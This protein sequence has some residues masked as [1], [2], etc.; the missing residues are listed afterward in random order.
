MTLVTKQNKRHLFVH[1][2]MLRATYSIMQLI[3]K[4]LDSNNTALNKKILLMFFHGYR[5]DYYVKV[6]MYNYKT[7]HG[8]TRYYSKNAKKRRS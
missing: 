1:V 4:Y 5:M 7:D 6:L 2:N 3:N 8:P